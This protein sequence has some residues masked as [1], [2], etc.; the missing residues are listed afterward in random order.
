MRF[1]IKFVILPVFVLPLLAAWGLAAKRPDTAAKHRPT[2]RNLGS[3]LVRRGGVDSGHPLVELAVPTGGRRPDRRIMER[4]W[5]ARFS[6]RPSPAG[7]WLANKR[8]PPRHRA[9]C[10]NCCCCCWCGWIYFSR[11]PGRKRSAGRFISPACRARCRR[12]VL[13]RPGRWSLSPRAP[14]SATC[15]CPTLTP[16]T[17]GGVSC[18]PA[19]ATC[20]TTFPLVTVS[21]RSI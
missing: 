1:P 9:G 15:F 13:A 17:S 6:S 5:P 16:T 11:R 20:S 12:R 7:W 19:I 4:L 18:S 8:S 2:G 3:G 10:G 14:R 21:S